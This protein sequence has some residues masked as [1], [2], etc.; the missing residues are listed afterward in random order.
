MVVGA[1]LHNRD[2]NEENYEFVQWKHGIEKGCL[3]LSQNID[4]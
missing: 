4:A 1:V 2:Q 3:D